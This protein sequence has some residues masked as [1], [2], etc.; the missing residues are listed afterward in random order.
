MET[1]LTTLRSEISSLLHAVSKASERIYL[2][3]ITLYVLIYL[4]LRTAWA[5]DL[6][7]KIQNIRYALLGAVMWGAA[8]Y[9]FFIIATWKDLWG[10]NFMLLLTG[11]VLLCATWCF[12]RIMSTNS[13]GAVMDIF[14]CVAAFGKDFRKMLKCILGATI[15]MLLI[16]GLGNAAGFTLDMVKPGTD[17]PGHSLGIN[18]PNTW[19]YIV[20]LALIIIWYLYLRNRSIITFAVFWPVSVFMYRYIICRTIAGICLVFPLLALFTDWVERRADQKA[21]EG[22]LKRKRS[23]EGLVTA[24]PCLAFAFMMFVSMQY[25]WVHQFYHGPLRNLAWRF[26]QSGLYFMTYGL[27]LIGNP[28]NSNNHTY[29]NVNGEFVEVG[30]LDSSFAAYLIM[31][32]LIWMIYTLLWLCLAQWKALKKRDYAIIMLEIVLLGFAMMERPGLDM[33]Y[34]FILLYPLAKV[35]SKPGTGKVLPLSEVMESSD[36]LQENESA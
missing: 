31:R 13:Y 18:Y 6:G 14:F 29:V 33:W 8:L 15:S 19:G 12:S 4:E 10:N 11:A 21:E 5:P 24:I 23:I 20:F 28:Y 3:L 16:A 1:F 30:I 32:G 27:P 7:L 17:L 22:T 2:I 26:L 36:D 34:N 35:G 9:L 25:K